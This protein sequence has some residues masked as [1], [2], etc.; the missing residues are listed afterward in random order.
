[1]YSGGY[2]GFAIRR[3]TKKEAGGLFPFIGYVGAGAYSS[4]LFRTNS[5]K[6]WRQMAS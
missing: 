6:Q 5:L 2:S 1:M 4:F 3:R